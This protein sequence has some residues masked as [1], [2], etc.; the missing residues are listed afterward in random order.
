LKEE[1]KTIEDF[2]D[3]EIS[4]LG[5]V[6]SFKRCREGKI[7]KPGKNSNGYLIVGLWKNKK[8]YNKRVHRLVLETFNPV[9]NMDKLQTNHINGIKSDNIYPENIEWCTQSENEKHAHRIGL[10]N[11]KGENHPNSTLTEKDVIE[12][13]RYLNEGIL[14]QREIAKKFG[15]HQTIISDIKTGKRWKHIR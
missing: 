5:R 15:V 13:W 7:L 3:Y 9:E 4:N 6:K 12:M 1:W 11:F 8:R 2:P 10:K 14:T